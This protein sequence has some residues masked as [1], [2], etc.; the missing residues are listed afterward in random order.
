MIMTEYTKV[1]DS[2]GLVKSSTAILNTDNIA[3]GAYK[4]QKNVLSSAKANSNRLDK[5]EQDI[6]EIKNMLQ[7]L[8]GKL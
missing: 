4:A 6:G 2:P 3:L 7:Q 1:K 5:V 8:L